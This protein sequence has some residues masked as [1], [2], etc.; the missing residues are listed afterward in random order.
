MATA[1][2][3]KTGCPESRSQDGTDDGDRERNSALPGKESHECTD[4]GHKTYQRQRG[5]R[6]TFLG[7]GLLREGVLRHSARIVA[8]PWAVRELG[9]PP[10]HSGR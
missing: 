7:D 10:L 8:L 3:D 1:C 2:L 6:L 9:L 4:G 5:Q